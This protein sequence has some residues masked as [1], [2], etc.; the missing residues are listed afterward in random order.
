[1]KISWRRVACF[2]L[3]GLAQDPTAIAHSPD[4]PPRQMAYLGD[5]QL[6][7]GGAVRNSRVARRTHWGGSLLPQVSARLARRIIANRPM[8]TLASDGRNDSRERR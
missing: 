5:L 4:Q 8:A 2:V 3:V 6:K 1:M 7:G